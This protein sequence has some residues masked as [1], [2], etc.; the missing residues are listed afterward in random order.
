M[1]TFTASSGGSA[2]SPKYLPLPTI[3]QCYAILQNMDKPRGFGDSNPSS[4][5][6]TLLSSKWRRL[7]GMLNIRK[8]TLLRWFFNVWY[9]RA[10]TWCELDIFLTLLEDF[11][12]TDPD[13]WLVLFQIRTNPIKD[14]VY[15]QWCSNGWNGAFR[16]HPNFEIEDLRYRL[17]LFCRNLLWSQRACIGLSLNRY[18]L[19]RLGILLT[20]FRRK[21]EGIKIS[22]R[23]KRGHTDHGSLPRNAALALAEKEGAEQDFRERL[24][25]QLLLWLKTVLPP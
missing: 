23:R 9:R 22:K 21:T 12:K 24:S 15:L 6:Y 25:T 19:R 7:V 18:F 4:T 5:F 16:F 8:I 11:S 14:T 1:T 3:S 2:F 20:P 13:C 17:E 10:L